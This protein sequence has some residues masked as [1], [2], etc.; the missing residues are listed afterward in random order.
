MLIGALL[1]GCLKLSQAVERKMK[2]KIYEKV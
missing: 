1:I 2:G